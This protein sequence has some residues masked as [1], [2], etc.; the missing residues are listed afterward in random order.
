MIA[1]SNNEHDF[2]LKLWD[3][4]GLRKVPVHSVPKEE[5]ERHR[6]NGISL[7]LDVGGKT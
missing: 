4:F 3:K 5:E 6:R 1:S 2:L 7:R